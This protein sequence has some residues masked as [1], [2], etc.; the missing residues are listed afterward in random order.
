ML[1]RGKRRINSKIARMMATWA[2]YRF[3][4]RLEN[5]VAETSDTKLIIVDEAYTTKTCTRCG[6]LNQTIGGSKVFK[7]KQCKLVIDR[8]YNGSRNIALK[9]LTNNTN[10][11]TLRNET[12]PEGPMQVPSRS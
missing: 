8:D 5:K 1:K 3:R 7:C 11:S 12:L 9:N 2:H 10:A 4:V 6:E